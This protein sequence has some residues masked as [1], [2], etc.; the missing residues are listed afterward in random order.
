M[1]PW[2]IMSRVV[3]VVVAPSSSSVKSSEDFCVHMRSGI[4]IGLCC[5][6]RLVGQTSS[7]DGQGDVYAVRRFLLS[8]VDE[9]A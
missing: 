2:Q 5:W 3:V 6:A 8:D 4:S 9:E 1:L 7:T